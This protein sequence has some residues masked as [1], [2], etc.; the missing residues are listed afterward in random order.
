M[1]KHTGWVCVAFSA[2]LAACGGSDSNTGTA[3]PSPA[4][5]APAI[6]A[7]P[8]SHSVTAGQTASFS[9]TASGTAPLAYQW[10][11][12]GNAIANAT[13]ATYTTPATAAA[14]N[15]ATFSVTVTNPAGS[16][17]S[18]AAS[19]TVAAGSAPVTGG[20][21][22]TTY[23]NDNTR[24]GLNAQET[25]LTTSNVNSSTFGKLRSLSVDGKVDAQPLVLSALSVAGAAHNVVFVATEHDSVYAFDA[26]SGALLW[27]ISVLAAGETSSDQLGCSQVVPEIGITATP[28][29]DRAAGSHGIM[30]LVAMTK[31]AG[32]AYHQRL[33]ALDVTTGADTVAAT[34]IGAMVT[35]QGGGTNTFEPAA[36]EERSALTLFGGTIYL[37]FTSHCDRQPYS[38]WVMAYSQASLVRSGVI[39]LGPNSQGGPAIWMAGG[40]PAVDSSG[41]L[42]LLTANG[43]FETT[44]DANGFPNLGDFGNSFV[45]ISNAAGT[46]SVSDYFALKNTVTESG[47][48][49][50]LGSGGAMALPDVQDASGATRHLIIGAGKDGIPYVVDRDSMGKFNPNANN[51]YQQLPALGAGVFS[52]PAYFNNMVFYG[53]VGLPIKQF[54]ITGGKLAAGVQSATSF[55]YPGS[56]IAISAN[57]ASEGIVWAHENTST[58]ALH[59]LK[60]SDLTEIYNSNQAAGG[61]DHFGAGN[62][63]I[64][65]TIA[66]GKVFVG[67][68]NSVGVFGLL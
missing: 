17:T 57:G 22:V 6:T 53:P 40:G 5:T 60:A 16:V 44:L 55:A 36:Y 9:V 24:S 42:Y 45:K 58:A 8:V 11:R 12:S 31:D 43:A 34:E 38:G 33:H 56:A 65:P 62:K 29:I 39:N 2:L 27:K 63:F 41:N 26:D 68:Q 15:G 52:T 35:T 49:L 37:A 67:T 25:L 4:A 1:T 59:A 7:Q 18:S 50:D 28:V 61:R 64:T 51:I 14:D 23:K 66:N 20:V 46:L 48:D 54:L 10:S 32:G 19:L 3:A 30:Y 47:S 21:D 13:A